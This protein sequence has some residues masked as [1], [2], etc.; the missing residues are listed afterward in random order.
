[1]LYMCIPI[2]RKSYSDEGL[3]RSVNEVVFFIWIPIYIYI[4]IGGSECPLSGV[5]APVP[6]LHYHL[7][8]YTNVYKA[9]T[10]SYFKVHAVGLYGDRGAGIGDRDNVLDK[11]DIISGT[12]G[13]AVGV[14]GGYI[15][16]SASLVDTVRRYDRAI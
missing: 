9:T 11:M 3:R 1:M 8:C 6:P 5:P 13:K 7:Y 12:L 14:I 10:F 2:V 15:A 16:A 4:Y